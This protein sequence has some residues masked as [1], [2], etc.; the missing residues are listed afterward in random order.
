MDTDVVSRMTVI[1]HPSY[2]PYLAPSDY[3][4]FGPMKEGLWGNQYG[5]V[6]EVKTAVL[7]WL[8][9]QPAE[10]CNSGIHALVHRW[11]VALGRG[12]EVKM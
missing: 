12:G 5:N 9:H 3:R 10:F 1:P 8:R 6:N 11:T 2:S 7:N 4:L